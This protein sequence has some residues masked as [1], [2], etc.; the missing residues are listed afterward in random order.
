MSIESSVVHYLNDSIGKEEDARR[1]KLYKIFFSNFVAFHVS[2][3]DNKRFVA[4]DFSEYSRVKIVILVKLKL[5]PFDFHLS[6]GQ[7]FVNRC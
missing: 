2:L 3:I 7:A 6:G 5:V 1:K 4:T